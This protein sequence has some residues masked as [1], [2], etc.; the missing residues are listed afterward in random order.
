MV[1]ING[2][3]ELYPRDNFDKWR[4]NRNFSLPRGGRRRKETVWKTIWNS[5]QIYCWFKIIWIIHFGSTFSS[6]LVD[7]F[8]FFITVIIISDKWY[9]SS[10]FFFFRNISSILVTKETRWKIQFGGKKKK[11]NFSTYLV[12]LSLNR[13]LFDV[14]IKKITFSI[15]KSPV[16]GIFE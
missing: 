7:R 10:F 8:L 12:I 3:Y 2:V 4:A 13:F 11:T 9:S 6:S 16:N 5:I 15:N 14:K 1:N